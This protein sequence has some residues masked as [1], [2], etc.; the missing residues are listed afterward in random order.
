MKLNYF[1]GIL[2]AMQWIVCVSTRHGRPASC[3]IVTS[4]DRVNVSEIE[5]Y[6][7]ENSPCHLKAVRFLLVNGKTI[8]SDPKDAWAKHA[9][10]KLRKRTTIKVPTTP[11][12][13]TTS[14][15]SPGTNTE[16]T[17]TMTTPKGTST[18]W[19]PRTYITHRSSTKGPLRNT[20]K[21]PQWTTTQIPT[22][23]MTTITD[24]KPLTTDIKT[25][26]M[27][28][29][30]EIPVTT[31][32]PKG[33]STT[34]KPR[35][36]ITHRSSTKGPLRNTHKP[37]QWTTTQIPTTKMTT[38]TD[39]KPLTTDIK[40]TSMTMTTEIPVRT[41]TPKGPSTTWKPRTYITHR[42]STKGPLRNTHKPPQW[43]T[44]QIPT[45]K[46]TMTTT[47][48]KGT[49]TKERPVQ[50]PSTPK[51]KP[52]IT[53]CPPIV[54][55]EQDKLKGE[56]S[57]TSGKKKIPWTVRRLKKKSKKGL[58]RAQMNSRSD[59]ECVER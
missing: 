39:R 4:T 44:T 28:M 58:R 49:S 1:A 26:S 40:T 50:K 10:E 15:S 27:T 2:L 35:T 22:T 8:C 54:I 38:I 36:Y 52:R 29:T 20:H 47:T 42:S 16:S 43:T 56:S 5:S 41:T 9:I 30:T 14:T 59:K 18:T 19:K 21:P 3:C 31:T 11:K 23:K 34:W 25:T 13:W 57:S 17:I 51:I 53:R 32:T 33:P 7:R 48:T 45:T 46:M 12:S 55:S 37:P 6:V 24:R